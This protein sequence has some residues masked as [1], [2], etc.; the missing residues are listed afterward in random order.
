MTAHYEHAY[1]FF[2]LYLKFKS[3]LPCLKMMR[4]LIT[5]GLLYPIEILIL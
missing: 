3:A 5:L 1:V 4:E 2:V